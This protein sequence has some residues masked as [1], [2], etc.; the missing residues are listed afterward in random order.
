MQIT[1]KGRIKTL[2]ILTFKI[3]KNNGKKKKKKKDLQLY[4]PVVVSFQP[5]QV[6]AMPSWHSQW[7]IMLCTI[8]CAEQAGS[9]QAGQR[10]DAKW[11]V[12]INPGDDAFGMNLAHILYYWSEGF[13][14]LMLHG[15]RCVV[16]NSLERWGTR[17]LFSS[18][19]MGK[20][21]L[22]VSCQE[23]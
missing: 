15:R 6:G 2:L 21:D 22:H 4:P 9:Q 3:L 17:L 20:S 10:M 23:N 16:R 11:K 14:W 8:W 18:W 13:K 1:A 7:P 12:C 19:Q 5:A